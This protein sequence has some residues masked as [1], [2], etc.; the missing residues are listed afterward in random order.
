LDVLGAGQYRDYSNQYINVPL[1]NLNAAKYGWVTGA[2]DY[3]KYANN[4]D[5]QKEIFKSGMLN[6]AHLFIKGGDEIAT[7]NISTGYLKQNA[8][9]DNSNF[10]RFNL[11]INGKVNISDKFSV[12][13]NAKMSLADSY[14]PNM[15]YSDYK[16]PLL[17]ALLKP[18]TMAVYARDPSTGV[19]LPFLDDAGAENVSNPVAITENGTGTN[20]DYNFLS[21]VDMQYKFSQNL[22]ISTLTGIDFNSSRES[23]F[24]PDLGLTQVDSAFNQPGDLTSEYRSMQNHTTLRY[25]NQT[26]NGSNY[27][28]NIGLRYLENS[29]KSIKL[30]DLNTASDYFKNLGSG[31]GVYT[32]LRT[33]T[34]DDR[35]LLWMSYFANGSYNYMNKYYLNASVSYDGNS[36]INKDHRYNFYPSVSAAWRL[37]SGSTKDW[38]EDF[39]VRLSWSQSGNILSNIYDYS[40]LYYTDARYGSN[41]VVTR[42]AIP[43]NDMEI[44]KK[45][46]IDAGIDIS[47]FK[48][49]TNIHLDYYMSSVNNL[50]IN[51]YLPDNYGYNNF[52]DNGGKLTNSGIELALDHRFYTGSLGWNLSGTFTMEANKI[53]SMKFIN[54]SQDKIVTKVE[55]AEYA[56]M[57]GEVVNA[58][59]GYKTKGIYTDATEANSVKGPK[60]N[61][62]QVG[63]IRY[64]NLDGVDANGNIV[65]NEKDKTII[66]NP[67]PDFYGGVNATVSYKGFDLSALFTYSVGNCNI[68]YI[69]AA[70]FFCQ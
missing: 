6:K 27:N 15:G 18:S 49:A 62:M 7:Y 19:Q 37:S 63:D 59:Y 4:T 65:I 24:L 8:L 32:Y 54:P 23:L 29:Y 69:V 25:S 51:Q 3:Y 47:L 57:E 22:V 31:T 68:I 53:S 43:N 44:E 36:A 58:F 60:G 5:W 50:V 70:S 30:L 45:S 38:L 66:G 42:E 52:Y 16:N 40:R 20:R 64:E 13:P 33:S 67:N 34:G 48:Q 10:S 56:S 35:G 41:G 14:L 12:A 2:T 61:Y 46:T 17:S 55:G 1:N 21:S 26:S 11:R 28:F 39:K 9:Y